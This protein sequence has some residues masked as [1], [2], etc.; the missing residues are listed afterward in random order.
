M[1]ESI[2]TNPSKAPLPYSTG[3][4]TINTAEANAI[5][6]TAITYIQDKDLTAEKFASFCT[7]LVRLDKN[8]TKPG[9]N[10]GS[11]A[12]MGFK[13]IQALKPELNASSGYGKDSE[14]NNK[15]KKGFQIYTDYYIQDIDV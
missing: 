7:Y 4:N 9:G 5:I 3:S 15:Y 1:I 6:A 13:M 12:D 14:T 2:F 10:A 8:S 11:I